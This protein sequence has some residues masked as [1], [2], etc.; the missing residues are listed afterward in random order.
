MATNLTEAISRSKHYNDG[1]KD[2]LTIQNDAYDGFFTSSKP[3]N[4]LDSWTGYYYISGLGIFD[5][6]I[7]TGT[8]NYVYMS[9]T[10]GVTDASFVVGYEKM[11]GGTSTDIISSGANTRPTASA[12][13]GGDWCTLGVGDYETSSSK[14]YLTINASANDGSARSANC[15]VYYND[16]SYN[17]TVYQYATTGIAVPIWVRFRWGTSDLSYYHMSQYA[18][19]LSITGEGSGVTGQD[20][21][22]KW[23]TDA[24]ISCVVNANDPSTRFEANGTYTAY[25]RKDTDSQ[26]TSTNCSVGVLKSD[27]YGHYQYYDMTFMY[28]KPGVDVAATILKNNTPADLASS[29][30]S[31]ANRFSYIGSTR[32][33]CEVHNI[34]YVPADGDINYKIGVWREQGTYNSSTGPY[35]STNNNSS[36][37][38]NVGLLFVDIYLHA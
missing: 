10:G 36:L 23:P 6:R 31:S 15:K 37:Q 3:K 29:S 17:F 27:F 33:N 32:T 4:Y 5:F 2:F 16:A 21:S 13:Y 1:T 8:N 34:Q 12:T 24:G 18:L 25:K 11:V 14:W 38:A 9:D 35:T 26:L 7:K 22:F 28:A 30:T 20:F 19:A